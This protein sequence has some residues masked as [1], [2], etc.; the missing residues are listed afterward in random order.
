[1]GDQGSLLASPRLA[2]AHASATY[3]MNELYVLE[4]HEIIVRVALTA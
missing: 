3:Y 2:N 4:V 1:M